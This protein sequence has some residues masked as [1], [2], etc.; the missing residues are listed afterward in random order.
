MRAMARIAWP[1]RALL[2]T[3][4]V[5]Q[6]ESPS[7]VK[8]ALHHLLTV[9]RQR[10]PKVWFVWR[11]EWASS[12]SRLYHPHVHVLVGGVSFI[13]IHW[14]C[15]RWSAALGQ[16][17]TN[18]VDLKRING[19]KKIRSYLSKYLYKDK[20]DDRAEVLRGLANLLLP[21]LSMG[22]FY[23]PYLQV[24]A[25]LFCL[26]NPGRIWG[27][28]GPIPWALECEALIPGSWAKW[29]RILAAWRA[30]IKRDVPLWVR[31]FT[32]FGKY[33]DFVRLALLE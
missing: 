8:A 27:M 23:V 25:L 33:S 13:P 30:I 17:V 6:L 7:H 26:S 11:Y 4:T 12:G 24:L 32:V 31:S 22:L 15:E 2:I 5:P 20:A 9:L 10:Y 14:L 28:G 19:I 3:L 29:R 18:G 21:W 1:Q 16:Q